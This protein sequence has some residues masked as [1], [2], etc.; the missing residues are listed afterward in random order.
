M[1]S[2][3]SHSQ[4]AKLASA[5]KKYSN[6]AYIDAIKTYERVANK[7]YKSAPLFE[8]LGNAYYFNA[9]LEQAAKWYG[10]LFALKTEIQPEYF[11]RYAQALRAT[12]DNAKANAVMT[13]FVELSNEDNRA[14]FFEKNR[15]YL[16]EIKKNTGRYEVEITGINSQYSDYGT[17]FYKNKIVFSSA[18]DTGSLG[19]RKHTWTNQYFTNLYVADL[20]E[21]MNPTNPTKF[22]KTINSKF[23]ESTPI[24]TKDGNTVYFTRNNYLDGKKGKNNGKVTL[25]KIYKA[26]FVNNKWTEV[27]EL[28][29]NS[30]N[31]STAH[32]SLSKDEKTLYFVSDMP[33]TLG[34][35]DLF[36]VSVNEN[37]TFGKPEN[38]GPKINTPGRETFPFMTDENELYFTSDGH[39][40]V[41]GLDLFVTKLHEDGTYGLVE[42]L[43]ADINSN[44][45]DFAYLID[46]KS[47]RGFFSS[48]RD[49]GQGFDDIYKFIENKPL[50]CEQQ[51][52]GQITD[53]DTNE[54]LPGAKVSVF[55]KKFKEVGTTIADENGN[56]TFMVDCGKT[57]YVRA[58]QTDYSTK[59]EKVL[60][61]QDKGK[62]ELNLALEKVTCKV[63]I[64]DDLGH[65]F[66]IKLIYFDLNKSDIRPEAALDLEKIVDVLRQYP[67]MKLDIRSHTDSR[68]SA[69][70]NESLSDRRAK[71]T[72]AWM[73]KNGVTADRLI[74]KGYGESQL[75]NKCADGVSCTEEEHQYNRRSEFI[76]TD[77]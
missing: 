49:G 44:K 33:G 55:D 6:F 60:T 16:A 12:G 39:P 20:D 59:E 48:N 3:S 52:F 66:G 73:I 13:K 57:Y 17:A 21:N 5:D 75:V 35:S 43:G 8:K 42:N 37:G 18:R 31:Y 65:C 10:E 2:I 30:E 51:L 46:T 14:D 40:G 19:Q 26:T 47:R 23:N 41:G 72:I 29:F 63:A 32:P 54:P 68:G 56:Y 22:D 4:K 28:P 70:Y 34:L 25:L 62:T 7:G 71:S 67:N 77:L 15:D 1:F 64:G 61:G 53:V 45:D 76:I 36:K 74:G 27:T 69:A 9:Q 24:F 38:L 50:T 11:Y 58:E